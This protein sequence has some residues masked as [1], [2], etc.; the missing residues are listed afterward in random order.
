[1]P[2]GLSAVFS[3][4]VTKRLPIPSG[5]A[6]R[7]CEAQQSPGTPF[8]RDP[9]HHHTPSTLA[10]VRK[11]RHKVLSKILG[12][13]QPARGQ[14][15][16]RDSPLGPCSSAHPLSR[17]FLPAG[18]R[19]APRTSRGDP[20]PGC[21]GLRGG[22]VLARRRGR[23]RPPHPPPLT[24]EQDPRPPSVR[25][26]R[27]RPPAPAAAGRCR[28]HLRGRGARPAVPLPPRIRTAFLAP[29][30]EGG[31]GEGRGGRGGGVPGSTV[32]AL[33]LRRLRGRGRL[34]AP[35]STAPRPRSP[36]PVRL[37]RRR[38][39]EERERSGE[40]EESGGRG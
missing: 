28:N 30:V 32:S 7:Q 5:A 23:P 34:R 12:A 39:E 29:R 3:D 13:G 36:L 8:C 31:G 19:L 26:A 25:G 24:W 22:G 20:R 38:E 11:H 21:W 9:R 1:M 10:V 14:G 4:W 40:E 17:P 33:R 15:R 37:E 35:G 16:V 2:R 18:A 27:Q 6:R